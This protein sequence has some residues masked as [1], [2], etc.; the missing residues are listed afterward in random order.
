MT[1][2]EEFWTVT[3]PQAAPKRQKRRK[4]MQNCQDCGLISWGERCQKCQWAAMQT[5]L[6]KCVDCGSPL[7]RRSTPAD[8]RK[9][10]SRRHQGGGRCTVCYNVANGKTKP[11]EE[12]A[13]ETKRRMAA[14]PIQPSTDESP[15][16][17]DELLLALCAQA[18]PE[19]WF[20]DKGSGTHDAKKVCANCP[21]QARCLAVS[22]TIDPEPEGVWGG[23]SVRTRRKLRQEREAALRAALELE[24]ADAG[25]EAA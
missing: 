3:A 25:E 13:P 22:L 5:P 21:I 24:Q 10:R 8:E 2:L 6:G 1:T 11:R 19:A 7:H 18:D 16:T 23:T 14:A 4:V 17:D 9:A 20:P 15:L 12:R